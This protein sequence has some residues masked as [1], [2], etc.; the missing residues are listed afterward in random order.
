MGE[1]HSIPEVI[2]A[3]PQ[4]SMCRFRICTGLCSV[5]HAVH[6]LCMLYVVLANPDVCM[7]ILLNTHGTSEPFYIVLWVSFQIECDPSIIIGS[8]LCYFFHPFSI[9]V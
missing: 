1:I 6:A 8:I 4:S 7:L 9:F 3:Q 5:S 2:E